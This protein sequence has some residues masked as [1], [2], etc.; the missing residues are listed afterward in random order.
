MNLKI[1]DSIISTQDGSFLKVEILLI[2]ASKNCQTKLAEGVGRSV[3]TARV[4]AFQNLSLYFQNH[5][6]NAGIIF[7]EPSCDIHGKISVSDIPINRPL[8]LDLSGISDGEPL[9]KTSDSEDRYYQALEDFEKFNPRGPMLN[10][11]ILGLGAL[12]TFIISIYFFKRF[13]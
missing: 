5:D 13:V 1:V 4:I 10:A 7:C 3:K 6:H 2:D 12:I 11:I 8:P 9:S